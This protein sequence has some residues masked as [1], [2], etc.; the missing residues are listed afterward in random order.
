MTNPLF[1]ETRTAMAAAAD[2]R[3][4]TTDSTFNKPG[5]EWVSYGLRA[6]V[7]YAVMRELRK[8]IQALSLDERLELA[9]RLLAG[10]IGELGHAGIY[11]LAQ[12]AREIEPRHFPA[13]D[14]MLDDFRG[15]SHVDD[16]CITVLQLVLER[17]PEALLKQLERWSRSPNRWKRRTSVVTF[18]RKVGESGRYTDEVL[19]LCERLAFDKEDLVQKGVGWALKDNMRGAP[20]RVLAFVKDLRRRARPPS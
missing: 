19:A 6:P 4:P 11:V 9:G 1:A 17:H 20:D 14:R 10:H 15:W 13:L 8:R 18:V 16:V 12:S 5:D 2:G 3:E 7:Y